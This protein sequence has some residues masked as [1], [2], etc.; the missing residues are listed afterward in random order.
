[1]FGGQEKKSFRNIRKVLEFLLSFRE[2]QNVR[3]KSRRCY[4]YDGAGVWKKQTR[5][6]FFEQLKLKFR[7]KYT[8]IILDHL[9][10]NEVDREIIDYASA[11]LKKTKFAW[12]NEY[13]ESL[14]NSILR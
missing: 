4:V 13:L 5:K 6:V 2:N 7:I 1:M 8:A 10:K 9:E 3:I 14:L 12:S 11:H